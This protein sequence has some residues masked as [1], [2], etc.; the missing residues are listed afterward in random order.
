MRPH[1]SSR[2]TH[3]LNPTD[4]NDHIISGCILNVSYTKLR[5]RRS[6][7]DYA[8]LGLDTQRM[9]A[10]RTVV[11]CADRSISW[12]AKLVL[13][14]EA[15]R[16]MYRVPVAGFGTVFAT[17]DRF[18]NLPAR[19]KSRQPVGKDW[20]DGGSGRCHPHLRRQPVAMAYLRT[21]LHRGGIRLCGW[22][23][24]PVI[25]LWLTHRIRTETMDRPRGA[26]TSFR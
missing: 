3:R 16:T 10:R 24:L 12:R 15:R 11:A 21:C 23:L 1:R 9:S 25:L 2:Q 19:R 18:P 13:S 26:A 22:N 20:P 7:G 6:A 17:A 14:H 8:A 5:Q 4:A